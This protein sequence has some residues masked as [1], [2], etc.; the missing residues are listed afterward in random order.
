MLFLI[1]SKAKERTCQFLHRVLRAILNYVL[2][3][4]RTYYAFRFKELTLPKTIA[5]ILVHSQKIPNSRISF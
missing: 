5:L 3:K 1:T 4:L 2:I